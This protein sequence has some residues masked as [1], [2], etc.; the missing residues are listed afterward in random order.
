[1]H[2]C[3]FIDHTHVSQSSLPTQNSADQYNRVFYLQTQLLIILL[4]FKST[5]LEFH[6]IL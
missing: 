4:R 2:L 3:L 5:V 1:M 6:N